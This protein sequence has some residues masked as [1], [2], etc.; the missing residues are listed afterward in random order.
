M[1]DNREEK[2]PIGLMNSGDPRDFFYQEVK[3]AQKKQSIQLTENVEFYLV[4]LMCDFIRVNEQNC[5]DECLV[6]LLKKALE[7]LPNEK[8]A[9]YKKLA[10]TSLYFCGFYQDYF[11]N[12]SF[13]IKYYVSMGESA[14]LALSQLMTGKKTTYHTTMSQIYKEMSESFL[15]SIDILLC[16]S[17]Q[18]NQSKHA[19]SILNIY[20]AWINTESEKLA[21]DLLDRG[22]IPLPELLRKVQ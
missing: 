7:S 20:D 11:A 19:R 15:H 17:E 12:K 4:Q 3:K 22:I 8:I 5:F 14:Y 16:I 1:D 6:I 9:L 13:D 10:D 2:Q 18:T 21:R